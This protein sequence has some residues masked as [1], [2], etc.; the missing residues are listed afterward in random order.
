MS[1]YLCLL[2][3]KLLWSFDDIMFPW[4]FYILWSFALLFSHLKEHSPPLIFTSCLQV[5]D[6]FCLTW[7]ISGAF[8]DIWIHLLCAFCSLIAEILSLYVLSQSHTSESKPVIFVPIECWNFS[9]GNLDFHKG[10][11]IH[12]SHKSVMSRCTQSVADRYWSQLT[13]SC[14]FL[15]SILRLVYMLPDAY[16]QVTWHKVLDPTTS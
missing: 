15:K 13:G 4:F 9:Y 11:L 7:F 5:R 8:S 14:Q 10:F 3:V 1:M 2:I 16:F 12:G 6:T